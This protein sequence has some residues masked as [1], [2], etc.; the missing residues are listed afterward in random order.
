MFKRITLTCL[1][2]FVM[3]HSNMA[4]A[5]RV[6]PFLYKSN[7]NIDTEATTQVEKNLIPIMYEFRY[8]DAIMITNINNYIKLL[9]FQVD[10]KFTSSDMKKVFT[11]LGCS[12]TD[13]SLTNTALNNLFYIIFYQQ[14]Y[15]SQLNKKISQFTDAQ[16][17]QY[18]AIAYNIQL[19]S[20]LYDSAKSEL[21]TVIR[22]NKS[23]FFDSNNLY[24][25]Q[26]IDRGLSFN[27]TIANAIYDNIATSAKDNH[28][29]LI[30]SSVNNN[31]PKN[32]NT[33]YN[34]GK[35]INI[36]LNVVKCREADAKLQYYNTLLA[37]SPNI[38]KDEL[39]YAWGLKGQ[40]Y[41]DKEDYTESLNC[42]TKAITMNPSG[43]EFWEDR[44]F[45]KWSLADFNGAISD[46]N[47][48]ISLGSKKPDNYYNRAC[49]KVIIGQN[50][51]AMKDFNQV[52]QR[53]QGTQEAG[54]GALAYTYSQAL[55]SGNGNFVKNK[56]LL[57]NPILLKKIMTQAG[58]I[59]V[60]TQS[61]SSSVTASAHP[62][63]QAQL[64]QQKPVIPVGCRVY[65]IFARFK[66][67]HV[68]AKYTTIA[69]TT[70]IENIVN[71]DSRFEWVRY[72]SVPDVEYNNYPHY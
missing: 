42:Y 18:L 32:S 38:S 70:D 52:Y 26:K 20:T 23:Q 17:K 53:T 15:K 43:S 62:A 11:E 35:L 41:K 12:D 14:H 7:F 54:L 51:E 56:I 49:S 69:K 72:E 46:Y 61:G 44:A 27:E 24:K 57:D 47:K 10:S 30:E 66:D 2:L 5:Q 45:V 40:L 64:Q 8:A 65:L 6:A 60:T 9:N 21:N 13:F 33:L 1:I 55:S 16:K 63:T 50:N 34:N 19:S 59:P 31:V 37:E 22:N 28:L 25:M 71:S 36:T 3:G 68:M 58:T 4:F 67:T 29:K 39:S 48:A